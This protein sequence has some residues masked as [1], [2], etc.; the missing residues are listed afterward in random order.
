MILHCIRHGESVYNAEGRIQGQSDVPLSELG[1]KQSE[2][3]AAALVG[4][5]IE[6]L[7]SS[8][9]RRA[10]ETA[11]LIADAV[12]LEIQT[13]PRLKEIDAGIFQD[14]LRSE[15]EQLYP[16]AL[17]RWLSGDPDFVIPGGESRRMLARRG[18]QALEAIRQ[19][20]HDEAAVVGHGR[21]LVV[22]LQALVDFP[23]GRKPAALH[24]GSITSLQFN[25]HGEAHV[26]SLNEVG[27]L[28]G[29]GA[30]GQGDL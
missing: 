13:D 29:V 6:A 17:A 5:P 23:P 26:L 18:C 21:A 7:Y 15:L 27:H 12:G 20:G 1:R 28:R 14:K 19:A 25:R 3:V 16:Q 10:M 30:G 9:L 22:T 4:L 2:A 8:P 11:R 24:N